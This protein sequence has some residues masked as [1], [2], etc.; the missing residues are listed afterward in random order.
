LCVYSDKAAFFD[1]LARGLLCQLATDISFALDGF[2][3]E[4]LRKRAEEALRKSEEQFHTLAEAMPQIV[5]MSR[6]DGGNIYL[7]Q[8][9]AVYTGLTPE[10][11][12]G[13]GWAK[14]FHPDDQQPAFD[15]WQEARDT[16]APLSIEIRLRRADGVYR[17]WLLQGVPEL[18]AAGNVIKWF[19]TGTDIHDLKTAEI[20]IRR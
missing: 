8:K 3:R 19:G 14:P 4:S 16:R 18:D 20:K 6:P 10:E 15:A 11:G 5:W 13:D 7:S 17:W 1:E 12:A 9:W 2:A